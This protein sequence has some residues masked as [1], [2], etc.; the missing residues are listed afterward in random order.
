[1]TV[2]SKSASGAHSGQ[3][4][5]ESEDRIEMSPWLPYNRKITYPDPDE[6]ILI[7]RD[8]IYFPSPAQDGIPSEENWTNSG[9]SYWVLY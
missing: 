2:A 5:Y 6:S 8:T 3:R 7:L 1:M 4:P 9:T